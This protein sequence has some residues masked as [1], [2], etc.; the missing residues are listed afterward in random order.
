MLKTIRCVGFRPPARSMHW[1][2]ALTDAMQT[3]SAG[4]SANSAQKLTA[5]ESDRFEWLRPSG[6]SIFAAE[7]PMARPSRAAN[8]PAM[9]EAQIRRRGNQ[10]GGAKHHDR[11]DVRTR[12]GGQQGEGRQIRFQRA[13]INLAGG[14]CASARARGVPPRSLSGV[15]RSCSTIRRNVSAIA[16]SYIVPRRSTIIAVARSGDTARR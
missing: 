13:H 6:S 8:R 3:A 2:Q 12:R 15:D 16:G 10:T 9:L 11:G 1:A 14:R 4:P 5:C 7:V